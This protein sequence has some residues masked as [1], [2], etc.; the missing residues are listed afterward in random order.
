MN[1]LFNNALFIRIRKK[2]FIALQK[3]FIAF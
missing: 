2:Q 3:L 1:V